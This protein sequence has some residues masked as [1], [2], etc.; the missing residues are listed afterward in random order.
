M[1]CS[2]LPR[3]LT[4]SLTLPTAMNPP[5]TLAASP[6]VIVGISNPPSPPVDRYVD[7]PKGTAFPQPIAGADGAAAAAAAAAADA[8]DESPALAV[9]AVP[10][11]LL[12]AVKKCLDAMNPS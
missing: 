2:A 3:A 10:M 1:A 4:T 6:S 5:V 8:G 9:S 11:L 12:A 7:S